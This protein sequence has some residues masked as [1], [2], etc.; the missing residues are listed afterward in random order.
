MN[1]HNLSVVLALGQGPEPAERERG[2][3]ER[4]GPSVPGWVG[5]RCRRRRSL[6]VVRPAV[7]VLAD[8]TAG[9]AS[10][11]RAWRVGLLVLEVEPA[12]APPGDGGVAG[13]AGGAEDG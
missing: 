4:A 6:R 13:E 12:A 1:R 5:E 8:V 2:P 10:P 3:A 9:C 11:C 7:F